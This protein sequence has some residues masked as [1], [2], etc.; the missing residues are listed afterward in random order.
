MTTLKDQYHGNMTLD[1][2]TKLILQTLKNVMEDGISKEN[3]EV[4]LVRS[5]TRKFEKL[6]TDQIEAIITTLS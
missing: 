6:T 1:E 4:M 2:A 5:E 3:V